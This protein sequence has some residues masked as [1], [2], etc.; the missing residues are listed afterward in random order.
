VVR[1]LLSSDQGLHLPPT[2]RI[3][4][5]RGDAATPSQ[6]GTTGTTGAL[7]AA[8]ALLAAFAPTAARSDDARGE[9]I[10]IGAVD[11]ESLLDLSVEAATRR[12]ERASEAP[13]AVFVLT[14]ADMR[15]HGF[16]TLEEVL[17]SVPGLFTYAGATP[18]VGVRGMG[19]LGDLTTRLL[20]LIDGHPLNNQYVDLGR[21]LPIPLAAIH[22][23]EVI[24]GPVGSVY[25]PSAFFGV[26]N[27]V[28]VGAAPGGE[29]W[30][31][32]EAAQ[33]SLSAG[34][35][36]VTRRGAA[37]EA[38]GLVS[39]DAHSSR[40]R[41]FTYPELA[42]LGPEAPR[43]GTLARM[44][45]GDSESGYA[46]VRWRQL[47][48]RAACGHSYG[49]LTAPQAVDGRNALENLTCFAELTWDGVVADDLTITPRL[50]FDAVEQRAGRLEPAQGRLLQSKGHDRWVTGELRADWRALRRLRLDAGATAQI[51][52]DSQHSFADSS[53]F[54]ITLNE[55]FITLS[56]WLLAEVRPWATLTLH[57]GVTF[58]SH[59]IFGDELTP[60]VA[61]VWQ[62]TPEDTVKAV[63][64]R[65]FRPPTVVEA[66]FAD[67]LFYLANPGLRPEKTSSAE[68][69]YERR[70]GGVATA[71]ASLFWNEYL[72]LIR[73]V[74][75]PA[76]DLGRPPDPTDARDFR[77]VAVNAG[78]LSLVGGELAI[79]LRW[80]DWLQ[81][82]GGVSV[83]RIDEPARPN[84]PGVTANLA[85]STRAPWRPLLLSVRAAG[86]AGRAKD[87]S[88]LAPG[89]RS[90]V[91]A[92]VSLAALAALDVP[93]AS[94]LRV[95]IS[96][97][98]ALGGRNASPGPADVAPVSELPEAPRTLRADLRWRF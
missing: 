4:G 74:T 56:A 18:Q 85:I 78:G 95:E 92:A 49:G 88:T 66:L 97:I 17:G 44:D 3:R 25:G 51:H 40:G 41:A 1:G 30:A 26:V 33:G 8:L 9:K 60:K 62:P 7:C 58:F 80:R 15:R 87:A 50:A 53:S 14:S 91:P 13:A 54:D 83:Q 71:S 48:A 57:G 52:D 39:V 84:F 67:G 64:S 28:T 86:A 34:E 11:I 46:R 72:D 68:L 61:A 2:S 6:L 24:K 94:G 90:A 5:A 89:Q 10:E 77:Q 96:V 20:I 93:G 19:V 47:G 42:A 98:N 37:G 36:S 76:P 35:L 23:V 79:T 55:D 43:G 81:A 32:V 29:A 75:V 82:Y 65:G 70:L 38:D 73:R 22:R 16:R 31:G 21:G 27:L 12:T 59:S 45:F 69:L 63:W